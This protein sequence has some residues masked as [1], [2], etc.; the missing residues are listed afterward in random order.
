MGRSFIGLLVIGATLT[1]IATTATADDAKDE[2]FN[3]QLIRATVKI[4]HDKSTGTG[5]VLSDGKKFILVTAAHVFD[6]TPDDETTI[7]FR[8]KESDG[9]YRKQPAK[10]II[11]KEGKSAWT[12][13]PTEDVAAMWLVP[14]QNADVPKIPLGLLAS[15]ELLRKHK[16]HPG[17]TLSCLGFP[18]RNE[19]NDSGFSLLRSGP[20]AS[21]PLVPTT[22]NKT[23]YL[24]ANTFEGDSGGPVYLTRT[25]GKEDL[26]FIVGLISGQRF[27]DEEAKMIYGTTK[28]RH[29][30]GLDIVVHGTFI[31]ETIDRLP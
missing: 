7:V 3:T 12:K 20:I 31:K 24:S 26:K 4:S 18:H 28:L 13:H 6:G 1:A 2:E 15:D 22:I 16:V 11:R 29:R 10:L 8:C 25:T 17:E 30:L 14:P 5:F 27:L 9:V 21:F 19:S 23:F